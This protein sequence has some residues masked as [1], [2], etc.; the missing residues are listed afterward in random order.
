[1]SVMLGRRAWLLYAAS[2]RAHAKLRI[3]RN[4]QWE[5][6]KWARNAGCL[7]YDFRGTATGD[8]P[9]PEDPGFGV[10]VFKKSFGPEFVRLA[11]YYDLIT[12]P[13]HHRLFRLGEEN[14]VPALYRAKV[15]FD[16]KRSART[17]S[18]STDPA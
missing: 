1:M 5:M 13:L 3:T 2:D 12:R 10:Y 4:V 9:S 6:L 8:P 18:S 15:W 7:A 14:V 11:G 16:E 17:Q